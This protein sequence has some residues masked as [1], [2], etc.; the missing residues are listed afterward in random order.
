VV[1]ANDNEDEI[2]ALLRDGRTLLGLSDAGAHASQLC[3]A[4]FSTHLLEHWVR[5]TGVLTLEQAIWRLTGQPSEVFRLRGRGRI[6]VGY[7]ADLVAFDPATIALGKFERVC[8]LPG[9]ADRLVVRSEGIA[10]TWVNGVATRLDGQDVVGARPGQ[11][12][13]GQ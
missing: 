4:G 13:A 6:A 5:K 7:A 2:G 11:L 12:L 9:G 1:L 8:D 10:A 3:D